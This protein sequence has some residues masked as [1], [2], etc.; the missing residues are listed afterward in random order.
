MVCI[1]CLYS[2]KFI[3]FVYVDE[4]SKKWAL[5]LF[6]W[7][8]CIAIIESKRLV[9]KDDKKVGRD[10]WLNINCTVICYS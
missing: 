10:S 4:S 6:D 3:I 8:G 7:D 2:N 9:G 5:I 1:F